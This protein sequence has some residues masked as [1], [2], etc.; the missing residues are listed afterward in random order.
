MDGKV[1]VTGATGYIGGRLVPKLLEL[2]Y[3]VKVLARDPERVLDRKWAD[4]V[5]VVTGNV[6]LADSL[7][8]VMKNVSVAYY[9]VHSMTGGSNFH[10]RDIQGARN[11]GN[12]AKL[13]G[14]ERIIYLGGLG[15]PEEDLSKHLSSRHQTGDELRKSGVPV[16]EFRAAVVVGAGSVSFEIVRY[17]VE[18]LPAMICPSW[19][20][21][22]TQP[23]AIDDLLEYLACAMSVPESAD[24]VIEIGGRDVVTYGDM[25]HGYAKARGLK[26][27]LLPVP[28]LTPRLSSYWVHLVTPI[29][30][31]IGRPLVEGL[32]NEVIIR[33]PNAREIFPDIN[34]VS[35]LDAVMITLED[36]EYGRVE[37]SW[38][39]AVGKDRDEI[40]KIRMDTKTGFN[41]EQRVIEV[42]ASKRVVY[43]CFSGIGAERGWYHATWLWKLRGFIDR[44][45]GGVGLRRGRRHPDD[46]RIGD[47]LDF[48]RVE[49]IEENHM[50]LLRAEMKVPGKAWLQFKV[51]EIDNGKSYLEQT[52]IFAPKGLF[53]LLYWYALY[54][55]HGW[56]FGGLI[57][58]IRNKSEMEFM[59]ADS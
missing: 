10:E 44:L 19:V 6:L 59:N 55:L 32:R 20:Y 38:S 3:S 25:I 56:I 13:N 8:E 34:P 12:A 50:V 37:T 28:F 48:W 53:G 47:A 17:L 54:P 41:L 27:L 51:T 22:K 49:D 2:G 11:F 23:I 26:R 16:T 57:K 18:R 1:L 7:E 35:Y 42:T 45:I 4:K 36:L 40:T 9:L 46:L 15:D 43:K 33:N 58:K 29:P 52:A 31:S 24:E 5:E 21:T 39:D 30:A 14:V